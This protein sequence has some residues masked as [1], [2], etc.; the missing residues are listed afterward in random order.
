MR[1]TESLGCV[2][3][4]MKTKAFSSG[5]SSKTKRNLCHRTRRDLSRKG[6]PMQL[7]LTWHEVGVLRIPFHILTFLLQ[8]L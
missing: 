5:W 3:V 2:C 1:S 7:A 6:F 8:F 4:K